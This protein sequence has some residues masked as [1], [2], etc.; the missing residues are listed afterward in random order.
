MIRGGDAPS[1]R[2][3]GF[4]VAKYPV[5]ALPLLFPFAILICDRHW[6]M[7]ATAACMSAFL[8]P[9]LLMAHC[10]FGPNHPLGQLPGRFSTAMVLALCCLA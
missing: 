8:L 4:P 9:G 10:S 7:L 6:E 5:G 2:A 1:E 3:R